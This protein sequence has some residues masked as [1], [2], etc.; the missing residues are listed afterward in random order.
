MIPIEKNIIVVDENG[1]VFESTWLKRANGL[2]K[3]GRARWL[4]EK[5]ICLACPPEQMEDNRMVD[6]R[7]VTMDNSLAASKAAARLPTRERAAV[8]RRQ[9]IPTPAPA[10]AAEEQTRMIPT[11]VKTKAPVMLDGVRGR[12]VLFIYY[13]V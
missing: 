3:K 8:V 1:T 9:S 5:T 7:Q 13:H 10:V 6:N 12:R 4:D 2:V 11:I